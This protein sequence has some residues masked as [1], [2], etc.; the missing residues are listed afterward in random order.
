MGKPI[1]KTNA[2]DAPLASLLGTISDE[3]RRADTERM[4]LLIQEITG[5]LPVV[6]GPS[7]IGFGKVTLRYDSGR[8]LDW[9]VVGCSP[10]KAALTL[11]LHVGAD[12][13]DLLPQL[14]PH[15]TGKACIY[16]RHLDAVDQSVLRQIIIRTW[17][18]ADVQK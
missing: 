3:R 16:L 10:R 1:M 7:I 18:T 9:F 5:A 12:V 14:G 15:T 11:Y 6:W 2:T 8:V 4:C 13:S 17:Q